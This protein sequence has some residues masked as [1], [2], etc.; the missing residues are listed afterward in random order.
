MWHN[1]NGYKSTHS[2]AQIGHEGGKA[3]HNGSVEKH[4]FLSSRYT[5]NK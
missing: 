1:I 4:L 5:V 3:G 2:I